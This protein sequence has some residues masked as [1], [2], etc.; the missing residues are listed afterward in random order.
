MTE[1]LRRIEELCA[2]AGMDLGS[3]LGEV[4]TLLKDRV[5]DLL[6]PN[7]IWFQQGKT[8][9]RYWEFLEKVT[10]HRWEYD[11]VNDWF[12]SLRS[13]SESREV[14]PAQLRYQ[15]LS[16]DRSTCQKCGRK[17]PNVELEVDHIVPWDSGGPTV[18]DNLQTLCKECNI[19]KSNKCF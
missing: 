3:F 10:R 9:N 4:E 16:R 11:E 19:G 6:T 13:P 18:I 8:F 1:R 2:L 15:V 5:R 17:A 12:G 7:E 14:I